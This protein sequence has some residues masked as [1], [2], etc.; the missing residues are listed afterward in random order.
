M[1]GNVR[2]HK[3]KIFSESGKGKVP[4]IDK[5]KIKTK[6]EILK[7]FLSDEEI[8]FVKKSQ[9]GNIHFRNGINIFE[10]KHKKYFFVILSLFFE[11][12][13]TKSNRGYIKFKTVGSL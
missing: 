1:N 5:K 7:L 13:L 3:K 12:P 8:K 9:N 10:S 6:E 2:S 4:Y 11:R